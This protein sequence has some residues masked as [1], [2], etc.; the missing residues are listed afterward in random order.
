MRRPGEVLSRFHLLEHA[1]DFAYE[2]RSN[3][4]DVYMRRLRRKIDEPFG[5]DSL[6]TVRGAGYRLRVEASQHEPSA[7]P[8]PG[9]GGIRRCDGGRPRRLGPFPLPAPRLPSRRRAQPRSA[10]A[11]SGHGRA[12]EPAVT[13]RSRRTTTAASSRRGESYAQ[14]LAPDGRVLDATRPLGRLPLLSSAELRRAEREPIYLD[15]PS[16]PG[17]NE[18]SRLLATKVTRNSRAG[19]ARRRHHSAEQRRDARQLPRRAADRRPDRPAPRQRPG[20]PPR[21]AVAAAGRIDA[22]PRG[23]RSPR[24]RRA[25]GCRCRKRGTSCSGSAR[26]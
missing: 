21:G 24:R 14:L 13:R 4:V 20:L 22:P 10:P 9:H 26:R 25:G 18:G 2:N 8:P 5:R 17:L 15:K 1:W 7:H 3:V 23:C 11:R 16:V 19:R 12:R 6:E